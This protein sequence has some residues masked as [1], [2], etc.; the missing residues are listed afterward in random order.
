MKLAEANSLRR[1]ALAM[2]RR[3]A[4]AV[5]KEEAQSI[6]VADFGLN[7]VKN[8]GLELIVYHNDDRYC[9]K[10]LI[11]FP[12]QT[13]PEHRHPPI[14]EWNIGKQET[15]RCR[16]GKVYLYVAGAPTPKAKAKIPAK[17]KPYFSVWHAIVLE[18]GDQYTISPN[19]LHWFQAGKDGA[20]VSEF[21]SKSMY[22]R[23]VFTDPNIKRMPV[24]E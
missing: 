16:W 9:A 2:L 18:Q 15:F 22:E 10:E 3:A 24:Y 8:M 20:I 19:T 13:C 4:I 17:Y 7:D 14:D 12:F 23:D 11:L 6:E 21:S 1:K 5:T